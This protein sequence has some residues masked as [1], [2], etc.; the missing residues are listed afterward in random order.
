[1]G[2][3]QLVPVL[4]E[5]PTEDCLVDQADDGHCDDRVEDDVLDDHQ[6]LP[7]MAFRHLLLLLRQVLQLVIRDCIAARSL[8][9]QRL[10][11]GEEDHQSRNVDERPEQGVASDVDAHVCLV[12]VEGLDDR[13]ADGEVIRGYHEGGKDGAC[14][15]L[16]SHGAAGGKVAA[17][18][19]DRAANPLANIACQQ[20]SHVSLP[21]LGR[22]DGPEDQH[23]EH[24]LSDEEAK[25]PHLALVRDDELEANAPV[26]KE[27]RGK[28]DQQ[29]VE[30]ALG[31]T[32]Q[33]G[34]GLRSSAP[35]GRG[36]A[37]G[38]RDASRRA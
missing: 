35:P 13:E 18:K 11:K 6:T 16:L 32:L 38:A 12:P 24:N 34:R 27:D 14:E 30:Q 7:H 36:I 8:L 9:L 10:A 22:G 31:G 5:G 23:G 37:H 26:A 15:D 3:L 4:G 2:E 28:G 33:G 21:E 25:A 1:M 19:H 17:R 29:G 20:N